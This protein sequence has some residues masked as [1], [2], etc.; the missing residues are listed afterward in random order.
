M[1]GYDTHL[2][3]KKMEFDYSCGVGKKHDIST[4]QH[5]KKDIFIKKF[6][7]RMYHL[8]NNSGLAMQFLSFLFSLWSVVYEKI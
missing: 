8:N 5:V 6:F 4:S 7:I 3:K 2:K 1:L